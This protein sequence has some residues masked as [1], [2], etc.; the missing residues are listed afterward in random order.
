MSLPESES[1][2]LGEDEEGEEEEEEEEK[3]EEVEVMKEMRSLAQRMSEGPVS[4]RV[5]DVVIKGNAKTKESLIEAEVL[6]IFR[7]VSSMQDLVQA[8]EIANAKL[9]RLDI[10]E[11]VSIMLDAGP[12]ELPDTANVVIEVVEVKNL[13]S[14]DVGV[15][16]RPGVMFCY[17]E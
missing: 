6:D 14:G 3:E 11:S 13:L 10:F 16:T 9:Q 17:L 12:S 4:L 7:S 1:H 2:V 5:H 8:A 15:F